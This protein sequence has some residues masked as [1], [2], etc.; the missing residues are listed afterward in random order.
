MVF[1]TGQIIGKQYKV[2]KHLGQGNLGNVY[3]V[4]DQ[5]LN[6]NLVLKLFHNY[7]SKD[8]VLI[9]RFRDKIKK[10]RRINSPG[11]VTIYSFGKLGDQYY[12]LMEYVL[13]KNLEDIISEK[14]LS[15]KF[16]IELIINISII[17]ETVHKAGLVHENLKPRNIIVNSKNKIKIIDFGLTI[18]EDISKYPYLFDIHYM[19]PEQLYPLKPT[20]S[21]DIY[22][23]GVI[24]YQV[25]TGKLPFQG[26]NYTDIAMKQQK[27]L[28]PLPSHICSEIPLQIDRVII[29]LLEKEPIKRIQSMYDLRILLSQ[30]VAICPICNQEIPPG[31]ICPN[32]SENADDITLSAINEDSQIA[33]SNNKEK[34][35]AIVKSNGISLLS[36]K[37]KVN[38]ELET[39]FNSQCFYCGKK[40]PE[41][42]PFCPE[43][44][45]DAPFD[46]RGEAGTIIVTS[47]ASSAD[48]KKIIKFLGNLNVSQNNILLQLLAKKKFRFLININD[49]PERAPTLLRNLVKRKAD[50]KIID[51]DDFNE[52]IHYN[53]WTLPLILIGGTIISLFINVWLAAA[54]IALTMWSINRNIKKLNLPKI[55]VLL[56]RLQGIFPDNLKRQ[57]RETSLQIKRNETL[58]EIFNTIMF[59]SFELL[60]TM[61]KDANSKNLFFQSIKS[62][63]HLLDLAGKNA[64]ELNNY[65]LKIS[66]NK[67]NELKN[68]LAYLQKCLRDARY[69]KK[70][71]VI[72]KKQKIV[73]HKLK[74]YYKHSKILISKY[75]SLLAMISNLD[76]MSEKVHAII[77]ETE[78]TYTDK[79]IKQLSEDVLLELTT[80][81]KGFE[82]IK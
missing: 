28:N 68:E 41:N 51:I 82:E 47:A 18:P 44:F 48:R 19:A 10:V 32:C 20:P 37:K 50:A 65:E 76:K 64:L 15:T 36:F 21:I 60:S 2:I 78:L 35:I 24:F 74:D 22:A 5:E 42:F 58:V 11:T 14:K 53:S 66:P 73:N 45:L 57:C 52:I 16:A 69:R 38:K 70:H 8:T 31:G 81:E 79:D 77:K 7:F 25:L 12:L 39:N 23:L 34:N 29:K 62:I 80:L 40:L 43:C 63:E 46:E 4:T 17:M 55:K 56:E 1:Q 54:M 71:K 9:N 13:G 59:H 61:K 67:E 49:D 26:E 33:S 72:Y 75:R 30:P 3:L 6:K 27:E